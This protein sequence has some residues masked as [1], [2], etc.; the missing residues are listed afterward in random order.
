MAQR[1]TLLLFS[2][3]MVF[4]LFPAANW[5]EKPALSAGRRCAAI[6]WDVSCIVMAFW[7]CLF[8]ILEEDALAD[9][10]GAETQFARSSIP[11]S[12]TYSSS[13]CCPL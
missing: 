2:A 13:F 12:A 3:I 7:A 6:A 10:S 11:I 1:A 5:P 8:L 9:R 4:L